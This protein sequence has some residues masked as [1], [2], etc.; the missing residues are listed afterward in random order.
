MR[1]PEARTRVRQEQ[2]KQEDSLKSLIS[3]SYQWNQA[4][5]R[6]RSLLF[7]GSLGFMVEVSVLINS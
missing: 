5:R 4:T 3:S 2:D 1:P 6:C 7:R